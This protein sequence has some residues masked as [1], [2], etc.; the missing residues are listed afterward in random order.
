MEKVAVSSSPLPSMSNGINKD[1]SNTQSTSTISSVSISSISNTNQVGAGEASANVPFPSTASIV[2][3]QQSSSPQSC[4]SACQNVV[5]GN[6]QTEGDKLIDSNFSTIKVESVA[7][8]SSGESEQRKEASSLVDGTSNKISVIDELPSSLVPNF[9]VE[10]SGLGDSSITVAVASLNSAVP[11]SSSV[12]VPH[13]SQGGPPGSGPA[14]VQSSEEMKLSLVSWYSEPDDPSRVISDSV[15]ISCCA[16]STSLH[17]H[18]GRQT[19]SMT[20]S[21]MSKSGS[22]EKEN[23]TPE[24]AELCTNASTDKQAVIENDS[25]SDSNTVGGHS[26]RVK[27]HVQLL[28][29][30]CSSHSENGGN[31]LGCSVKKDSNESCQSTKD[32]KSIKPD[33]PRCSRRSK[34]G[35]T[36]PSNNLHCHPQ[37]R[38]RIPANRRV[39]PSTKSSTELKKPIKSILKRESRG[40]GGSGSGSDNKSSMDSLGSSAELGNTPLRS[41]MTRSD[42]GSR[43]KFNLNHQIF[44]DSSSPSEDRFN[45]KLRR[46]EKYATLRMRKPNKVKP[47]EFSDTD[48]NSCTSGGEQSSCC[49]KA[50]TP[51][52]L[53]S[54]SMSFLEKSTVTRVERA[55]LS[56]NSSLKRQGSLRVKRSPPVWEPCTTRTTAL[57]MQKLHESKA[58]SGGGHYTSPNSSNTNGH[59]HSGSAHSGSGESIHHLNHSTS[60]LHHHSTGGRSGGGSSSGMSAKGHSH[61]SQVSV[62]DSKCGSTTKVFAK[63]SSA[64]GQTAS[65]NQKRLKQEKYIQTEETPQQNFCS[66]C[67]HINGDGASSI[68]PIP[69]VEGALDLAE[70]IKRL[71]GLANRYRNT[72][73]RYQSEYEK[74]EAKKTELTK[75]LV[76]AQTESSEMIDFLQAEKSTLAESLTEIENEVML[77]HQLK[78]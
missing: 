15:S 42:S 8:P 66:R 14:S 72:A 16:Q 9:H 55:P 36:T 38:S 46:I 73:L 58:K 78:H 11:L 6:L 40:S 20:N 59:H 64:M 43:A 32:F 61:H 17:L 21:V 44:D 56:S 63:L 71:E 49:S 77:L 35:S 30:K 54:K 68:S 60:S 37:P 10:G 25:K 39:I 18:N 7:V 48:V 19:V 28:E 29:Q 3:N 45:S 75:Q 65:S 2:S 70:Q 41:I 27:M 23:R 47:L 5:K 34:S 62:K 31:N 57:R 50:G 22:E 1:A 74:S 76:E 51:S 52:E 26:Q 4:Q 33:C 12:V 69:T 24:P 53:M 67:H 13:E